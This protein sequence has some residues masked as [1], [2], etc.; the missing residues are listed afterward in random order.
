MTPHICPVEGFI[1]ILGHCNWCAMD[2]RNPLSGD[3]PQ[4]MNY[5]R[6]MPEPIATAAVVAL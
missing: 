4:P 5:E 6:R 3:K 1:W 2:G